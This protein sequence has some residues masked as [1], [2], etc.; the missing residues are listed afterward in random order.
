MTRDN[1]KLLFATDLSKE[2]KESYFYAI[3]LAMAFQGSMTLLHVIDTPPVTME[4]Q[5]KNLL[6]DERYEQIMR[7]H[8]ND[9]RSILIGKRKESEIIQSALYQFC[10]DSVKAGPGCHLQPDEILVRKGEIVQTI[11]STAKEKESDLIVL[12]SHKA[13]ALAP[14]FSRVIKKVLLHSPVPVIVVPPSGK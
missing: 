9:A 11:L 10:E 2:C 12:S 4:M 7:N 6:G 3:K 8:E 13:S 1:K 5:V 14:A